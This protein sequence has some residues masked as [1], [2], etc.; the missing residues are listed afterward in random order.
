MHLLR[1]LS[2][3]HFKMKKIRGEKGWEITNTMKQ[4]VF[5]EVSQL[6][7]RCPVYCKESD[8]ELGLI[9]TSD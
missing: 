2:T 5:D 8:S 1:V 6:M 4:K 7:A 9:C 3:R